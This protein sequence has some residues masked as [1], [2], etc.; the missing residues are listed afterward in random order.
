MACLAMPL[1]WDDRPNSTAN[2]LRLACARGI[3]ARCSLNRAL[4]RASPNVFAT[5]SSPLATYAAVRNAH[6]A[7]V[8]GLMA[9]ASL[10]VLSLALAAYY[11]RATSTTANWT[12]QIYYL[13]DCLARGIH[14][15]MANGPSTNDCA[16]PGWQRGTW[17]F[18]HER[19]YLHP[20][21]SSPAGT[22]ERKALVLVRG[23]SVRARAS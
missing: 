2:E 16:C 20:P 23:C 6:V 15:A 7:R 14:M 1:C 19:P 9:P 5:S 12:L 3:A 17:G 10:Q 8:K 21:A 22:G 18:P 4:L 11:L 13:Q